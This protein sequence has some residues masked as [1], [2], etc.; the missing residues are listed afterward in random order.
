MGAP[1]P[2]TISH[3][4]NPDREIVL[5][6]VLDAPREL[7]FKAWTESMHIAQWWGP[8]GFTTTIHEMDVRPGGVWRFIMH[9][10]DG[11]DYRNKIVY[12][13]VVKPEYL[14]YSQ[15]GD[16]DK[17]R[18]DAKVTF[19]VEQ[20]AKTKL[21]LRLIFATAAERDHVIKEYGA[22]EGG[23]QTLARLAQ[24][25]TAMPGLAPQPGKRS[26][27]LTRVFDASRALVFKA[28]T[29]PEH[30]R[31]WWGPAG[32]VIGTCKVDLRPGG[33]FLYSVRMPN[34]PEMWGKFVY[35]EIVPPERL[36]FVNCFS[37]PNGGLTRHPFSPTWPL[38]ILNTITLTEEDEKTTLTLLAAPI[39]A[40]EEELRTFEEGIQFMEKG[41]AGTLEQL[42]QYL[43]K[44]K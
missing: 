4:E 22:I 7:V 23:H 17:V 41:F 43:P 11:R 1:K 44:A 37:D 2:M 35:R 30:L 42:A 20:S 38:E 19:T 21:T 13:E 6:R 10:P 8:R 24:Y 12:H 26:F 9:G 29:E 16:G 27:V 3:E 15:S 5:T 25:V 14:S 31:H 36:V 33:S 32:W 34:L 40:T 39:N 28:W 18:F